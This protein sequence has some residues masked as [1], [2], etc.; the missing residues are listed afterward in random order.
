MER[1]SPDLFAI[2]FRVQR[3]ENENRRQR[4]V[5]LA[6]V[7][8]AV[9]MIGMA[10]APPDRSV[11]A[12][13]LKQ[14]QESPSPVEYLRT[15]SDE[16]RKEYDDLKADLDKRR[17]TDPNGFAKWQAKMVVQAQMILGRFGY[18][19]KFTGVLDSQTQ[20][21]LR[22]Y[23]ANKG[24]PTSGGVDA[25]T[26]YSLTEDDAVADTQ[27]VDFGNY[28]FDWY[29]DYFSASGAWDHMNSSETSVQSLQL[30]CFKD[31]GICFD[32]DALEAKVLGIATITAGLTEFKITKWDQYE[33]IA[34]DTS[35][36]C[37]RDELRIN[38]QEN[39][40]SLVST[41]TYKL[42]SCKGLLGKPQT[43]TYQLVDGTKIFQARREAS[44]KRKSSLYQLS[45]N[46]KAIIEAKD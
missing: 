17:R 32:F 40:V 28:E 4:R 45:P 15:L 10:Q 35:P 39:N 34:E 33:L 36:D 31:R 16:K 19:T 7:L 43:V 12:N 6:V 8:A 44:S 13:E 24:I 5:G 27:L 26:Y 1:E 14:P 41:P 22:S 2:V 46:A 29:D 30:E 21:A 11:E 38:H 3:L 18:G 23:Q 9:V 42:N 37:E 20:D 25:L